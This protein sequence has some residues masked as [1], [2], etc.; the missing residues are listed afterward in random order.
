LKV[1]FRI[2]SVGLLVAAAVFCAWSYVQLHAAEQHFS[3]EAALAAE[4][5]E[6]LRE[7]TVLFTYGTIRSGLPFTEALA[8]M[9]VDRATASQIVFSARD[10]YNL[11]RV[12]AG[13]AVML[14]RS[15][16]G[17]LRAVR[18]RIDSESELWV[19]RLLPEEERFRAEIKAIPTVTDIVGVAGEIRGS[20]FVAVLDA[21]E[22]P[23]L[24]LRLAD[25][26]GWDLDFYTDPRPGD[27]FRVAVEK[28][29]YLDGSL[30]G[31][32][33]ILAAEY[34]NAGRNYQAVLFR[35]PDGRAAYY[36]PD[37]KSLKKAFL[38]SPLQFAAPVTSRFSRSRFHPILKTRRPHLGIDYGAPT[39]TPVQAIG[40]GRV[41]F[42]GTKGGSGKMVHLRHPNG[43]ETQ[44]L[45]LSRILVR[46]GDRVAQG[47][48]IGLVG[49]TGL[50]TG[51]HLDFRVIQHGQYRNFER[52]QLP[53]AQP[54]A[55]SDWAEFLAVREQS[56]A[57]LPKPRLE[58]ELAERTPAPLPSAAPGARSTDR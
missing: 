54:V 10:T 8:G 52:L 11:A 48:R 28:R 30:V 5:A 14:G 50:A 23:E 4:Q 40:D 25:I 55:Q 57:L 49:A 13:N 51:P 35:D 37:G 3:R 16:E 42:A 18:Y 58:V 1:F 6:H 7:Q 33:R 27:T 19:S 29:T 41:A 34:N 26:F 56:L 38:K 45:H 22:R 32:G 47:Q 44:Y 17:E 2:V 53:P 9:G 20:L 39:G 43:Y 31:Y 46:P 15:L 21:G 24:A 36:A 12:R